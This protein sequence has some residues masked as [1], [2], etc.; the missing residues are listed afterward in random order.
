MVN[1]C[2]HHEIDITPAGQSEADSNQLSKSQD[3]SRGCCQN[4]FKSDPL[5]QMLS[6]DFL[7]VMY[8]QDKEFT[9]GDSSTDH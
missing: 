2:K 9:C 7:E 3:L 4:L 1:S 5:M 6:A 8:L